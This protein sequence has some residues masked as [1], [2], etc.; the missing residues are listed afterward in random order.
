[1][2]TEFKKQILRS[3]PYGLYVV[4]VVDGEEVSC[5]TATW[6]SQCSFDPPLMMMA[7][8]AD[9]RAGSLI[10][11]DG[12]FSINFLAKSQTDLAKTFFK[13]PDRVGNKLGE[14]EF[15]TGLTGAPLLELAQAYLECK[16]VEIVEH[17]DHHVV[18]GEVI[19]AQ[20]CREGD[21]LLLSDTNWSYGG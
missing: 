10:K 8:R 4:G 6:L 18:L 12:G 16:V 19:D 15:Y 3:I 14:V 21:I 9:S 2:N 5:F 11:N 1:M 17:G 7:V 20:V 13:P